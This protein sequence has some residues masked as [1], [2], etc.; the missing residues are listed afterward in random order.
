MPTEDDIYYGLLARGLPD[1]AAQGILMNLRDESGLNPGIN[2]IAPI[3][4]GSRGGYGL[5]QWTGPRRVALEDFAAQSGRPVSDMD[6]QLDFL[7]QELQGPERRAYDSL[8]ASGDAGSAGAA[9]ATDFL[10]PAKQHLDRRVAEYQGST[11]PFFPEE[12]AL[13]TGQPD[14]RQERVNA[15]LAALDER[16][17]QQR[18]QNALAMMGNGGF[19][20]ANLGAA[21][22]AGRNDYLWRNA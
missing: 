7:M 17:Q 5:A 18:P 4:P 21:F 15:L 19:Q 3:V 6:V 11:P 1:Y 20:V 16:S 22:D 9:F 14:N 13:R 10:R 12:N 8:M 2:E